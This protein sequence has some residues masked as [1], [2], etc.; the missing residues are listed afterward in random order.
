MH[1]TQWSPERPRPPPVSAK[2]NAVAQ[3]IA[4]DD[5]KKI[6][7]EISNLK[8]SNEQLKS[9]NEQLQKDQKQLIEN[10][11][12]KIQNAVLNQKEKIEN[13]F[14]ENSDRVKELRQNI[15]NLTKENQV[16][17]HEIASL[18]FAQREKSNKVIGEELEQ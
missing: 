9:Q 2:E 16:H 4:S 12:I 7:N 17:M 3:Y 18:K 6:T 15:E 10:E 11:Q 13:E 1:Q 8:V 5:Y 14:F